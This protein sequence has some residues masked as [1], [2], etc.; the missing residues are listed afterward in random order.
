MVPFLL[1]FVAEEVHEGAHRVGSHF[2]ILQEGK[3]MGETNLQRT[4]CLMY[5][6][7]L[8]AWSKVAVLHNFCINPIAT[9]SLINLANYASVPMRLVVMALRT[10]SEIFLSSSVG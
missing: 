3:S 7:T 6:K 10:S 5:L 9:S 8:T 1:H 2:D 4:S